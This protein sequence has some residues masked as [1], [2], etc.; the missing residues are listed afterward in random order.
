M[1]NKVYEERENLVRF[2]R[3]TANVQPRGVIEPLSF[4]YTQYQK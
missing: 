2:F 4:R 3:L 1:R